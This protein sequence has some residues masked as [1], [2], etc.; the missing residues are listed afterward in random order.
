MNAN[1]FRLIF[2][3]GTGM[4]ALSELHLFHGKCHCSRN[5]NQKCDLSC[6]K[7][8]PMT[9]QSHNACSW[10]DAIIFVS[11]CD[12]YFLLFQ[13]LRMFCEA[14]THYSKNCKPAFS[15]YSINRYFFFCLFSIYSRSFDLCSNK[16]GNFVKKKSQRSH[17]WRH[18]S[19]K[20]KTGLIQ[21][22]CSAAAAAACVDKTAKTASLCAFTYLYL[23]CRR[24]QWKYE[25]LMDV[26]RL[27]TQC[28]RVTVS[29]PN[30]RVKYN[31]MYRYSFL[32]AKHGAVGTVSRRRQPIINFLNSVWCGKIGSIA[33]YANLSARKRSGRM[34]MQ[35]YS[36]AFYA[37]AAHKITNTQQPHQHEPCTHRRLDRN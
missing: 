28:E 15:A 9:H 7:S 12:A 24:F 30:A 11:F 5:A 2:T 23:L 17:R 10:M 34:K 8:R 26:A 18:R 27:Q 14:T 4:T 16:F 13:Q 3:Q 31:F 37:N 35:L 32:A 22:S 21:M 1:Y 6:E 33:K 20:S 25:S 19:P 36:S 29:A